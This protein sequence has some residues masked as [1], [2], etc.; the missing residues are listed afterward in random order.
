M[1]AAA[2]PITARSR[3]EALASLRATATAAEAPPFIR[4]R[5]DRIEQELDRATEAR[6][7][8]LVSSAWAD[9]RRAVPRGRWA[10]PRAFWSAI[11]AG[12]IGD[13]PPESVDVTLPLLFTPTDT[14]RVRRDIDAAFRS[15][16]RK[17]NA[18]RRARAALVTPAMEAARAQ[19]L[20]RWGGWKR[21][22]LRLRS[23]WWGAMFRS[24]ANTL[25]AGGSAYA[26]ARESLIAAGWPLAGTVPARGFVPTSTPSSSPFGRLFSGGTGIALAAVAAVFI[27][28]RK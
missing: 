2:V 26:R 27:I 1:V 13:D 6:A 14:Q 10:T 24:A 28:S 11:A 9:L 21:E 5:I 3:R 4:S 25:E 12:R 17:V 15:L 22:S 16:D 20:E 8:A 19:F 23:E 7:R 18:A